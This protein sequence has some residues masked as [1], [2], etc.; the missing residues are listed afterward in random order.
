[1]KAHKHRNNFIENLCKNIPHRINVE[2]RIFS[3][4]TKKMYQGARGRVRG[5]M[6]WRVL[7]LINVHVLL[8]NESSLSLRSNKKIP[9]PNQSCYE[10]NLRIVWRYSNVYFIKNKFSLAESAPAILKIEKRFALIQLW[11]IRS[12]VQSLIRLILILEF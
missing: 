6:E 12:S 3:I 11:N 9:S 8:S 10:G 5:F 1:M 2:K 4:A 7:G